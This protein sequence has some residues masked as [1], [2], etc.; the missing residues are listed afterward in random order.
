MTTL[1]DWF[2]DIQHI[3]LYVNQ[4]YIDSFDTNHFISRFI[5]YLTQ[6]NFKYLIQH[7][8]IYLLFVNKFNSSVWYIFRK[9][10]NVLVEREKKIINWICFCMNKS[11]YGSINQF[12]IIWDNYNVKCVETLSYSNCVLRWIV[13]F[14]CARDSSIR[15]QTGAVGILR[16]RL[17]R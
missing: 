7:I 17:C 2:I 5:K 11:I 9:L 6:K 13:T 16:K 8:I 3:L 12:K 14:I 15:S 1:Y 10:I 4:R